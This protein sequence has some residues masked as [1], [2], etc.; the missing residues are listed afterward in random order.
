VMSLWMVVG[1]GAAALGAL[2]LGSLTDLFGLSATLIS[3]GLIG[4][5][6]VLAIRYALSRALRSR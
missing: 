1:L 2:L 5:V 3:A 6:V 4:I